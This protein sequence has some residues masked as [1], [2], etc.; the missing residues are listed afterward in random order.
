MTEIVEN[1]QR[2][3]GNMDYRMM[4]RV[5]ACNRIL[6]TFRKLDQ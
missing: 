6:D 2:E 3:A 1:V 4:G 5:D